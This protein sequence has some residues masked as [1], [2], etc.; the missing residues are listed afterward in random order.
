MVET[1][2]FSLRG[3]GGGE[4]AVSEKNPGTAK[5]PEKKIV[6][7]PKNHYHYFT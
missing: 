7:V 1:I 3:G 5:T 2:I 6:Q 4:V